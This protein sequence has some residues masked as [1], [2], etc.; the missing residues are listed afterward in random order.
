[1]KKMN[2]VLI[3]KNP[4][5]IPAIMAR[6]MGIFK[7]YN[8]D[9]NLKIPYDFNF[10]G[11]NPFLEGESD[12]MMGDIT[13]FFYMMEKGKKCIITS[14][15]TRTISLVVSKNFDINKSKGKFGV[16]RTGMFKLFLENDLKDTIKDPEIVW[17]NNTYERMD[18]LKRGEIEGLIAIEPFITDMIDEGFKKVWSLRESDRNLVMWCFDEEFYLNNK[19]SVR[20]FHMALEEAKKIFNK[21][22]REEKVKIGL[23]YAK[24]DVKNSER[25]KDFEFEY[26]NNFRLEDFNLCEEWMYRNSEIK[27]HYDGKKLIAKIF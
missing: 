18:A 5:S 8:I 27:N 15:I 1:M 22:S 20:N 26:G 12:A 19:E 17:M 7:K 13:F 25:L 3:G 9:V 11:K 23:E 16:N 6:E 2:L 10:G 14:N 21:S 24:Y 4:L